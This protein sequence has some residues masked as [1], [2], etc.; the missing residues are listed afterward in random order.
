MIRPISVYCEEIQSE[1]IRSQPHIDAAHGHV[2][3]SC[4]RTHSGF[5][6][7]VR[8]MSTSR[9]GRLVLRSN[10]QL[11]QILANLAKR[12]GFLALADTKA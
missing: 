10:V 4:T 11:N 7:E 8:K 9:L 3:E 12:I 2:E 6:S 1:I 5:P